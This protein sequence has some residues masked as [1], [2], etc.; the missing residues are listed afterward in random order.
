[1]PDNFVECLRNEQ[2]S[3][4]LLLTSRHYPA[5]GLCKMRSHQPPKEQ[6]QTPGSPGLTLRRTR[7]DCQGAKPSV[8][9]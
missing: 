4:R 6:H 7:T 2:N 8:W 1:V 5:P 9:R 3:R